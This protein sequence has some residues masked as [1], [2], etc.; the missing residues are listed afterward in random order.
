[1]NER[2]F[3]GELEI[4]SLS[5]REL[6][7]R[8][9]NG[10][11][12]VP[13]FQRPMRWRRAD[14]HRLL[15][16]LYNGY[17]IGTLLL[18]KRPAPAKRILFGEVAI[19]ASKKEDA[20]W[21]VDG[22]QRITSIVGCLLRPDSVLGRRSSEFA[23]WFDLVEGQF[24]DRGDPAD[25]RYVPV[26][27]LQDPVM[28]GQWAREVGAS[29]LFHGRAQTVSARLL[30]YQIP[31]YV[32]SAESDEVL[33][34]IFTRTNT[35]GRRMN[36]EEV[37]EALNKGMHPTASPAGL[38]ERLRD[39]V[40][41]MGFGT[42]ESA[43]LRRA[44]VCVAGHNPKVALPEA[45]EG[46]GAASRWEGETV[47]GLR[48][49]VM[50]LRQEAELPHERVLPSALPIIFLPAFFHRFPEPGERT[51]E[52]LARW[53]WRVIAGGKHT[54]SN[55]HLDPHYK[56][57]RGNAE[58]AVAVAWLS[59]TVRSRPA[60]LP[61]PGV[62]DR[63]GMKTRLALASLLTLGPRGLADARELSPVD[64]FDPPDL[65]EPATLLPETAPE[66]AVRRKPPRAPDLPRLPLHD[67]STHKLVGARFLHPK[68]GRGD[69]DFAR[70]LSRAAPDVLRSHGI[71]DAL[72]AAV[73]AS[74]W[75]AVVRGRAARIH[76]LVE[77]MITQHARWGE[78]DDGPSI[79]ASL[80]GDDDDVEADA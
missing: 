17:P 61:E 30:G 65:P 78:D 59:L 52:L 2:A 32:T 75:A 54:A 62:Y 55:E 38:I 64:V 79:E 43:Y 23:F 72:H 71:D 35:A 76:P 51:L 5:V 69:Q 41:G 39:A 3:T 7:G 12:R 77:R 58:E 48:R 22:Q 50:F 57:L 46:P 45:L 63:G 49:A 6:L 28:T 31:A 29:D 67:S 21:I 27:R 73:R 66:E 56:A 37:F 33:R 68:V 16:S 4:K 10:D 74:D 1:M 9:R 34:T 53:V 15:D 70:S 47:E 13:P 11:L 80:A 24:L 14:H 19:D 36:H 60:S 20:L 42:V 44:L 40:R 8:A 18:W 25:N 26:N